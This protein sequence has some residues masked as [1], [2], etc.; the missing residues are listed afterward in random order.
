MKAHSFSSL[1]DLLK[2]SSSDKPNLVK[3]LS[4]S[5]LLTEKKSFESANVADIFVEDSDEEKSSSL[6][7]LAAPSLMMPSLS[8]SSLAS[9]LGDISAQDE[10]QGLE[11]EH[12]TRDGSLHGKN[13]EKEREGNKK[14]PV[15]A[16]RCA[17]YRG[18]GGRPFPPPLTILKL[19]KTGAMDA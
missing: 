17:F 13:I 10:S 5:S 9:S 11:K 14:H 2:P 6:Y 18:I 19:C 15:V 8:S 12:E 3:S 4:S 1:K 16:N 7:S